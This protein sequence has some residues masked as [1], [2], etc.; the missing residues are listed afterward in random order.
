ML[1]FCTGLEIIFRLRKNRR[2]YILDNNKNK[3]IKIQYANEFFQNLGMGNSTTYVHQ[4]INNEDV[5]D[6][7]TTMQY[8]N[9]H[10]LGLC[11]KL[12]SYVA[13]MFYARS[14]IHNTSVPIAISKSIYFLSFSAYTTVFSWGS[15]N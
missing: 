9:M 12:Y 11:I 5:N 8:C 7:T 3:K 6:S 10:E 4:F 2:I 13:H 14:L 1:T 15:V